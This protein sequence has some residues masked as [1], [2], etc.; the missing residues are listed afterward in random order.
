ML[1]REGLDDI[2]YG[3]G[4]W[5]TPEVEGAVQLLFR[6]F[7]ESGY[8]P[9]GL[10]ALTYD[11]TN[12]L[13]FSGEAA[14]NPTGTWLVSTVVE[15]VQDFEVGFFPFPS[16]EGSGIAPPAG[17]G[18]GL[19]VAKNAR[20]PEG[21]IKF[22]DYLQ[23][24]DTARLVMEKFNTIPAH[25]VDTKG[26]DVPELFKSVLS[27]LSQS[28]E[29]GSFGYNIDVLT[30]QNFNEVMFSGFQEVFNGSRSAKEQ[31]DA[32]QAAWEEAKRKGETQTQ[33]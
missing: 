28:T 18:A 25:P 19:F 11:D 26:L 3:D 17:V 30:P 32:L 10:N 15:S 16:I 23:Q 21:A 33:G 31:V 6:D 4:K 7:V 1:G 2:L 27:D 20:N 5:N 9:E 22:I 8:Y 24:D 12:A 13:F 29:A 14:M